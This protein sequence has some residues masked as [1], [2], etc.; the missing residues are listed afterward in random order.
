MNLGSTS[1]QADGD[2]L[3]QVKDARAPQ[4]EHFLAA[5]GL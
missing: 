2:G 4:R 1:A 3:R 5:G